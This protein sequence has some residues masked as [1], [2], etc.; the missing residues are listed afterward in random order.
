MF[1]ERERSSKKLANRKQQPK[2]EKCRKKSQQEKKKMLLSDRK[3]KD[4]THIARWW[5]F[6]R[7]EMEINLLVK[8]TLSILVK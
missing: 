7:F 5:K 2:K 8:N 3:R 4:K 1:D 6:Q